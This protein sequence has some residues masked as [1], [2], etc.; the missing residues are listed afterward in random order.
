MK[1]KGSGSPNPG[2][3]SSEELWEPVRKDSKIMSILEGFL[4]KEFFL[5]WCPRVTHSKRPFLGPPNRN[6]RPG[7]ANNIVSF[8]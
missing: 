1:L 8:S 2:A 6:N 7:L 5:D 4:Q 3:Q